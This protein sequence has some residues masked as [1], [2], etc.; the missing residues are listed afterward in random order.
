MAIANYFYPQAQKAVVPTFSWHKKSYPQVP[1]IAQVQRLRF[2]FYV[3]NLFPFDLRQ[4][5]NRETASKKQQKKDLKRF[6][7]KLAKRF[8]LIYCCLSSKKQQKKQQKKDLKRFKKS[9]DKQSQV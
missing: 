2:K 8:H 5:C 1:Q 9:I 4:S 7:K 3:C 6:Q